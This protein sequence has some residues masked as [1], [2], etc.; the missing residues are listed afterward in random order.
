MKKVAFLLAFV[1]VQLVALANDK[2]VSVTELPA[3]AQQFIKQHFAGE[4]VL[5]ATVDS[6][7]LDK[8]YD[9]MFKNNCKVEFDKKGNWT[10][11]D[12]QQKAV[13]AAIVPQQIKDYVN[14]NYAGEKITKI[15]RDNGRYEIELSNRLDITFNKKFQVVD[16]DR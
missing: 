16:I 8:S 5:F 14:T 1:C 9:V 4:S 10:E 3:M 12:C 7:I 6:E 13:P 15:E 11:V 2:P